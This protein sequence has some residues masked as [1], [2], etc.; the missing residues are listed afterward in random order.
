MEYRDV[1]AATTR[2]FESDEQDIPQKQSELDAAQA[3]LD[4]RRKAL[5]TAA[6]EWRASLEFLKAS[7]PDLFGTG[8]ARMREAGRVDEPGD[9]DLDADVSPAD[10]AAVLRLLDVAGLG[11]GADD[12]G[13][14]PGSAQPVHP[15]HPNGSAG[16]VPAGGGG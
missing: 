8:A 7:R 6:S 14:A 16:G 1:V 15:D 2:Q 13:A 12:G 4:R 5:Q 3:L 10:V 11:G 9:D